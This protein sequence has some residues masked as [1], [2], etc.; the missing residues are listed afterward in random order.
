MA[1]I[2][3]PPDG[4][5]G[6]V[7]GRDQAQ[8]QSYADRLKTNVRWNQ[9]L[10]RNVLEITLEN[11]DR[12]SD[13]LFDIDQESAARLVKILGID[14]HTQVEGYQVRTGMIR[15]AVKTDVTVSIYGLDFNAP[16]SFVFD[17]LNKF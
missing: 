7:V 6:D 14:I 11:K 9:R 17:Y 13:M 1:G 2:D 16:D 8:P 4:V 5:G 15:P 3:K 10:K 12:A